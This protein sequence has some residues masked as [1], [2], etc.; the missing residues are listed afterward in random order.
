LQQLR[1][2]PRTKQGTFLNYLFPHSA[3]LSVAR[4]SV[5]DNQSLSTK[6]TSGSPDYSAAKFSQKKSVMSSIRRALWPPTCG[7]MITFGKSHNRLSAGQQRL[8]RGD[9]QARPASNGPIPRPPP[10]RFHDQLP[11]GDVHQ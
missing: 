9:I 8:F 6:F 5:S 11:P 1:K 4:L 2:E 7:V 10:N 3:Q